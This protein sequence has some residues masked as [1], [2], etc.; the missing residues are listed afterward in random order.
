MSAPTTSICEYYFNKFNINNNIYNNKTKSYDLIRT[1]VE[2]PANDIIVNDYVINNINGATVNTY[3]STKFIK[4]LSSDTSNYYYY[5][6]QNIGILNGALSISCWVNFS[7]TNNQYGLIFTIK[8]STGDSMTISGRNINNVFQIL[9]GFRRYDNA[10][11]YRNFS[12]DNSNS[13]FHLTFT[14]QFNDTNTNIKIFRN[15][16]L[17]S[18]DHSGDS[19]DNFVT[20]NTNDRIISIINFNYF[21]SNTL[22]LYLLGG[23]LNNN[24]ISYG[25]DYFKL[26]TNALLGQFTVYN[27]ILTADE[28]TYLYNN[29]YIPPYASYDAYNINNT[30]SLLYDTT[31]N[32]NH[33]TISGSGYSLNSGS[34][35]G[36]TN[37]I[38]YITGTTNTVINW[39][40]P[41]PSTYS[42]ISVTR[43]L[44]ETS[45]NKRILASSNNGNWLHG[46][47]LNK[48]GVVSYSGSNWN[49]TQNTSTYASKYDWT[50][51]C[52]TNDS[53]TVAPN[54]IFI[55][56]VPSGSF[57]GGTTSTLTINGGTSSSNS[58]DFAF[59]KLII[60][61]YSLTYNE[62][63]SISKQ[64][65]TELGNTFFDN[66][67]TKIIELLNSTNYLS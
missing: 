55:N 57:S 41:L 17:I 62:F 53:N 4:Q 66:L 43:Y 39:S 60:Y 35:N 44:N 18:I 32:G 20:Y 25:N 7:E 46:H 64:L 9:I 51:V 24:Y 6:N 19:G 38:N 15:G 37:V 13:F 61:D 50:V 10:S 8:S 56:G 14:I 23:E 5:L 12:F 29:I 42:I 16:S 59:Y 48:T 47:D 11:S 63:L 45:T 3:K 34:G 22:S 21:G 58:S 67:T 65:L 54:N 26:P 27:S 49:T 33:A 30:P 40:N 1:T 31:D 28:I 36:A 2:S 52:G